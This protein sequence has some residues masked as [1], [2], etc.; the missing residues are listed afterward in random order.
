MSTTAD[1]M[2]YPETTVNGPECI[3]GDDYGQDYEGHGWL[4]I[5]EQECCEDFKLPCAGK[6]VMDKWFPSLDENGEKNCDYGTNYPLNYESEDWL[7]DTEIDC[8]THFEIHHCIPKDPNWHPIETKD[9]TK[10]C[11]YDVPPTGYTSGLVFPTKEECCDNF[12]EACKTST[13]ATT[14]LTTTTPRPQIVT[15]SCEMASDGRE[16]KWWP[17][18]EFVGEMS[19]LFCQYSTAWPSEAK[20][21]TFDDNEG[22]GYYECCDKYTCTKNT[23]G[24][25]VNIDEARVNAAETDSSPTKQPTTQSSPTRLPTKVPTKEPTF[26]AKAVTH[27]ISNGGSIQFTC[28]GEAEECCT[29]SQWAGSFSD[30]E[31]WTL[32]VD[33]GTCSNNNSFEYCENEVCIVTCSDRCQVIQG[34]KKSIQSENQN[35]EAGVN[36]VGGKVLFSFLI[37]ALILVLIALIILVHRTIKINRRLREEEFGAGDLEMDGNSTLPPI[38]TTNTNTSRDLDGEGG[39]GGDDVE[40]DNDNTD[41]QEEQDGKFEDAAAAGGDNKAFTIDHDEEAKSTKQEIV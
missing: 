21:H 39:G 25:F 28:N 14:D 23:D 9:G 35:Q 5:T 11:L 22:N 17:E 31:S 40:D 7:F 34:T 37:M 3:Y 41:L 2:W 33:R 32:T 27:P 30:T 15:P 18:I 20:D 38:A 16:C 12:P 1:D 19:I 8:C 36:D 4:Y 13:F 26:T 10:V 29:T 6:Y 24:S